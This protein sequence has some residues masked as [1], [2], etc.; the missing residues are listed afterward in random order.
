VY[1]SVDVDGL[2]P[3]VIPGTSSPEP[4]GFTYAQAMAVLAAT[5]RDNHVVGLDLVELAPNLDP[6]GRSELLCA[7]LIMETVCAVFEASGNG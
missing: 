5:A 1:I 6:T 4:D 3:S 2:D 7:R